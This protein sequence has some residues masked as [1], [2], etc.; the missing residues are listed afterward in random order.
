M[1]PETPDNSPPDAKSSGGSAG[2]KTPGANADTPAPGTIMLAEVK[3][4]K[5]WQED[6]NGRTQQ[7]DLDAAG[8]PRDALRERYDHLAD[9]QAR[10]ATATIRLL[11][12]AKV[13]DGVPQGRS[14]EKHGDSNETEN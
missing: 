4:L 6:L 2:N 1:E 5:L 7:L 10:L 12:P 14:D 3:F 8:K 13:D 11:G 9:E